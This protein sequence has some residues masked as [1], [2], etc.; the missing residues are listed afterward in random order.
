MA[1]GSVRFVNETIAYPLYRALS[2]KHG[3]EA[4]TP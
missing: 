3:G 4:V 2:T 1:D